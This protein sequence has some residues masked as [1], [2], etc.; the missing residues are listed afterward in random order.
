MKKPILFLVVAAVCLVV[1][2]LWNSVQTVNSKMC[3]VF[4]RREVADY[5]DSSKE[6]N[7]IRDII[8]TMERGKR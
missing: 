2:A 8:E 5:V 4:E 6:L 1:I 7:E 3:E